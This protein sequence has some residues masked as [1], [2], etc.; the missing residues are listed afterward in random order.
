MDLIKRLVLLKSSAKEEDYPAFTPEDVVFLFEEITCPEG[1]IL[2]QSDPSECYV[3][4]TSPVPMD[5][6]YNL[7]KDPSWVGAPMSLTIRQPPSSIF[8]IVSKLLGK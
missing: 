2:N 5:E 1:V 3:L 8:N 4:F 6:I 7:N